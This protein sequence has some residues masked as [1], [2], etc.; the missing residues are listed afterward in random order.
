VSKSGF[1]ARST[2]LLFVNL[3]GGAAASTHL[4]GTAKSFSRISYR[5]IMTIN[6][7][8]KRAGPIGGDSR[9]R[10]AAGDERAGQGEEIER[11]LRFGQEATAE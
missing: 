2:H 5:L 4:L 6:Q 3:H 7:S 9:L 11:R 10:V 8:I 1:R